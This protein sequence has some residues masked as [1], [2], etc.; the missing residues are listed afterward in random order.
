[1]A[2]NSEDVLWDPPPRAA[3]ERLVYGPEPKQFADLRRPSDVGPHPLAIVIHGGYWK[4]QYNLIHTGHMCEALRG[5]GIATWNVEYRALG[6]VGCSWPNIVGDVHAAVAA[7]ERLRE[8]R[9]LG[10]G[11]LIGHSAGGQ[12]ALLAAKRTPLPVLA[13]AAIS[14][15]AAVGRELPQD[16]SPIR[17]LP[18]GVP[19]ILIHGTADDSVPFELSKRYAAAAGEEAKLVALDAAGHFEAI[20]PLSREWPQTLD[21]IRELV[22]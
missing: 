3:D 14:D 21:A 16:A 22:S 11:V 6:D 9:G 20:D 18:L 2:R 1:V 7:A 12:L 17:Q 19:Q 13:L 8:E 4:A 5:E 15:P 10:P